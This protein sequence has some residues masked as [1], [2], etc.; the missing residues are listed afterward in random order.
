MQEGTSAHAIS[1]NLVVKEEIW[2]HRKR[3][4]YRLHLRY[5]YMHYYEGTLIRRRY[6][7]AFCNEERQMASCLLV[8]LWAFLL[9]YFIS[10]YIAADIM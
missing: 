2:A 10:Y 8:I 7:V 1:V 3:C 9:P 6:S 4:T 5:I